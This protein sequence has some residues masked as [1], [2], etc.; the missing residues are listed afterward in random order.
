[1]QEG[2]NDLLLLVVWTWNWRKVWVG[3]TDIVP[4]WY[5]MQIDHALVTETQECLQYMR[6]SHSMQL[7]VVT[8][9]HDNLNSKFEFSLC[10]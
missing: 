10:F 7:V 8:S 5:T 3:W 6:Y 4:A 2:V 1:M 9:I